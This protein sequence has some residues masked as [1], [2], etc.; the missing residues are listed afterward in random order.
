DNNVNKL[1][2]TGRAL[3]VRANDLNRQ[4]A[5]ND[6]DNE[7]F[8]KEFKKVL[9]IKNDSDFGLLTGKHRDVDAKYLFATIQT[10]SRD[11]N[12]KQFDENE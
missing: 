1:H 8:A 5:K 7:L 10:L 6:K 9:P 12:F 2:A 3:G 4:M 11:D